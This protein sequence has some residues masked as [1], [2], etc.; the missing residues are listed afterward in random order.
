MSAANEESKLEDETAEYFALRHFEND[1]GASLTPENDNADAVS[2]RTWTSLKPDSPSDDLHQKI[3]SC[4]VVETPS[5]IS[6]EVVSPCPS[7]HTSCKNFLTATV[8]TDCW[9]EEE[10]D[11]HYCAYTP[12]SSFCVTT[13]PVHENPQSPPASV[14]HGKSLKSETNIRGERSESCYGQINPSVPPAQKNPQQNTFRRRPSVMDYLVSQDATRYSLPVPEGIN[15]ASHRMAEGRA[16]PGQERG[17]RLGRVGGGGMSN[18]FV[19]YQG[20]DKRP[21]EEWATQQPYSRLSDNAQGGH[22]DHG[23]EGPSYWPGHMQP[24]DHNQPHA[25]SS[26]VSVSMS[27]AQ[28]DVH[29]EVYAEAFHP[30]HT[31]RLD[32]TAP[33]G[34]QLLA[35]KLSGDGGGQP[36][37]PIYRRFDALTHRLLLYMQ[38][39]IADLERQLVALEAKDTV[40]RSYSGGIIPASRRQDRWINGS[41]SDQKTEILGLIGYKLSQYNQVLASFCKV[42]DIPVPTW[43]DIHTYK[44]YLTTSN[45]I[46]DD[47]TRFLDASNDLMVLASKSQSVHDFDAAGD[48]PTPMPRAVEDQQFPTMFKDNGSQPSTRAEQAS[49]SSRPNDEMLVRLAC[50]GVCIV[51]VPIMTFAVIPSFLG[52]MAVVLLV[53]L[54]VGVV[55]EQSGVMLDA[56]RRKPDWI[57]YLGLYFGAMAVVAGAVK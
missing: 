30:E 24:W 1:E 39:E 45:L 34:Y 5:P 10:T 47:E 14:K 57:L 22:I 49:S 56:Q 16:L 28:S 4:A 2:P 9:E 32:S 54:G 51:F 20:D 37:T 21:P 25:P 12:P 35:A 27:A 52:R 7:P 43:R 3:P 11:D 15:S 6:V 40:K 8:E 48:G 42:Q 50:A 13:P 31:H 44:T 29:S 41:L 55:M 19:G 18:V 26:N 33:S 36:I 38:D 46:V 53:A 17:P 23:L